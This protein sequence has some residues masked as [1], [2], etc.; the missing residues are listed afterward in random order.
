MYLYKK[1]QKSFIGIVVYFWL[2]SGSADAVQFGEMTSSSLLARPVA[3]GGAYTS[4]ASGPGCI[5]FN[6]AALSLY[7]F[8]GEARLT[9]FLNPIGGYVLYKNRNQLALGKK[10][11]GLDWLTM[12]GFFVKSVVYSRPAF[13]ASIVLSEQLPENPFRR[14]GKR[15][16]PTTGLVDWQYSMLSGRIRLADQISVGAAG[17]LITSR[18]LDEKDRYFGASYG[19]LIKPSRPVSVGIAYYDLPNISAT[20]FKTHSRIID[21]TINVGISFKPSSTWLF[22]LDVR[23]V[24]EELEDINREV[25]LGME[26]TLAPLFALRGGVFRNVEDEKY[27]YAVGMGLLDNGLF[28][29]F[30]RQFL[31]SDFIINYAVQMEEDFTGNN[32][33]HYLTVLFRL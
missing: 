13:A 29:S 27:T 30:E 15:F 17:Y 7:R 4:V 23:N 20:F 14:S 19:V 5:L 21:E 6:P 33:Y 9:F 22:A 26:I 2:I 3:M 24:S 28:R 1:F 18:G 8:P 12:L 16:F 32:F 11:N 25:H 10:I 31:S